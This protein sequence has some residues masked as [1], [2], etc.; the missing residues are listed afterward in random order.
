[1]KD[2]LW[3]TWVYLLYVTEYNRNNRSEHNVTIAGNSNRKPINS[4]FSIKRENR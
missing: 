4:L 2:V 1:M 3:E